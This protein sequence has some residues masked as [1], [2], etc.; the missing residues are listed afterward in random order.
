MRDNGDRWR[1]MARGRKPTTDAVYSP[2]HSRKHAFSCV[3]V[4]AYKY[5]LYLLCLLSVV[6]GRLPRDP[7]GYFFSLSF[8]FLYISPLFPLAH[9][10]FSNRS[11]GFF[12]ALHAR[13]TIAETLPPASP[14]DI[15]F[16][17][18]SQ[19]IL[20]S[21]V[22][23]RHLSRRVLR[24][25]RFF[26][27]V[28]PRYRFTRVSK[29]LHRR[30]ALELAEKRHVTFRPRPINFFD[31]FQRQYLTLNSYDHSIRNSHAALQSPA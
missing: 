29:Y 23:S 1:C 25:C 2:I 20:L 24:K 15:P 13:T 3:C 11:Y 28:Y 30:T 5:T 21:L 8:S 17:R 7:S 10:R 4:C 6:R 12:S 19:I 9:V 31:L 26:A 27:R 22:S 18:N 14:V 16:D